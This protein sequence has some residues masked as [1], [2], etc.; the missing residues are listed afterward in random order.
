MAKILYGIQGD[1]GGHLSRALSVAELLPGHE[2]LFVGGGAAAGARKA[3]YSFE[4][5]PVVRTE[6]RDNAVRV[7]ATVRGLARAALCQR[8]ITRRLGEIITAFDPD[9][10]FTDYEYYTP[11]AARRLGRPCLSLDHQHVLGRTRY[12]IPNS[13]L[14]SK[15]M[16]LAAMRLFLPGIRNSLIVSFHHPPLRNP[17]RDALFGTLPRSDLLCLRAETG[18]HAVMYLPDCD[19][20]KI[21]SLFGS[22]RRE[23][24]VYGLGGPEERGN[25]KFCRPGREE[26]LADLAGAAYVVCCGGHGLLTEALFFGKPCL[27][28][29]GRF[30]YEPFWNSYF[31]EMNGY[32]RCCASFNLDPRVLTDFEERLD[33]C[34]ARIAARNHDG[35]ARLRA[36]LQALL[37]A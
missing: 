35:R 17:A 3:G 30:L 6:V 12:A 5:L 1:R 29:P 8:P 7:A 16:T 25:V 26:F 19:R 21:L 2:L 20:G 31:M 18:E 27:C 15:Y 11:R 33:A 10:I 13:Q 34:S 24:R 14:H 36:H 32:G 23:Y 22:R 28:F 9:L 37:G 4:P